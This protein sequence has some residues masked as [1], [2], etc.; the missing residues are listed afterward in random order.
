MHKSLACC[1]AAA[2]LIAL[3]TPAPA[4]A[5]E[6]DDDFE[7]IDYRDYPRAGLREAFVVHR[8]PRL[9]ETVVVERQPVVRKTVV[10]ERRPVIHKTV[11]IRR[12]VVH[13]TVVV[14]RRPVVHKTVVVDRHRPLRAY[15]Y[16]GFWRD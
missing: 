10:I 8:R 5:T 1:F 9:R 2:A 6:L 7:E 16:A 11:V 3:A 15:G 13:K 14:E 12:P 4:S